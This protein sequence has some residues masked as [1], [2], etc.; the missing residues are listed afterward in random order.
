MFE[1]SCSKFI[2]TFSKFPLILGGSGDCV[3]IR[4]LKGKQ[5]TR[6]SK[7]CHHVHQDRCCRLF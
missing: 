3:T 6:R 5:T 4:S 1:T 2:P 7:I